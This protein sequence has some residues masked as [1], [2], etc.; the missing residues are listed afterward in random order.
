MNITVLGTGL[1]GAPL[2]ERLVLAGHAVT[3]WNR[4][5]A[6]ARALQGVSVAAD[7]AAAVSGAELLV[8]ALSDFDAIEAVLFGAG[9]ASRLAGLTVLQMGTISPSQSCALERDVQAVGASYLE[10]PVLGSIPEARAGTLLVMV[11]GERALFERWLPVLQVLG[12]APGYIGVTGQ[13]AALKLALNQMIAGLT[14]SFALS[15]GLVRQAGID[16]EQF[17]G[18][19]RGSALYAP[20]FDKKLQ[21]MQRRDY[22]DPNFPARHLLKDVNLFL[23]A[24]GEAGLDTGVLLALRELLTDTG[25]RGLQDE[26]YSALYESIDPPP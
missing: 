5:V 19:L 20:T 10:A 12:S 23:D 4:H 13:A 3:A 11:G 25:F 1:M 2:A 24:A 16:V 6:R 7:V 14:S 8:L 22:G 17:M 18:I 21:R 26:D 9:V 15:L